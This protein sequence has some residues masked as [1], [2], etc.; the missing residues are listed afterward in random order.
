DAV[1]APCSNWGNSRP[2]PGPASR[3]EAG[4]ASAL[5]RLRMTWS[6]APS[7]AGWNSPPS[8]QVEAG[9]GPGPCE[10]LGGVCGRLVSL[11]MTFFPL[12]LDPGTDPF[13]GLRPV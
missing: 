3:L 9:T 4:L 13:G 5:R 6:R 1:A 2:Q 11:C 7:R 12:D 8:A 10:K